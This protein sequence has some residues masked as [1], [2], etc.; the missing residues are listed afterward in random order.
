MTT[1]DHDGTDARRRERPD[2]PIDAPAIQA[3]TEAFSGPVL[4]P[5]D[6]AYDDA[7]RVWN[8][9]IDRYPA[10]IARCTGTADVLA[11][12]EFAREQDLEIAVRGGGHN[13]AGY[14]TCDG[15][16]VV[17]L[18]PMDWVDV[19]PEARTVRVGGGA[20]WG[21]VDRETQAFGL[22]APGG[23][24]STTGVAGLTLGGGYGYLRR[25]HGLSCDNLLAVDLV[26]ADGKFLTAS[27][28]EHAELFWAVRGGG[29]NFGIVTAFEFRLHPVG[30][31]VATVETW[32]S[33]SDAPSLVR[34]WR[35]AVATAPDEISAELV[36]WSVPDDPA[37]PDEL[38]TEPVAIVAAVYS[39]DVEAGERAMAPL[40]ELGA[41]LFDFSGPTPYVDLQQDFDPF[42][43]A[44]EFRYYAKSIFLD[45]LTDE[46][47]ETILE[48]AA[49]RPHYRVL[50]DIW[51]LGGAIADVSE[52]ETAYS[53]REHPYLLAIDATWEDPDDDE[54]VVAWSRA[55]WEDMREFSPGGL[56]LNFPGLEG[57]REDQLRETHGS[58]TY[59]RLVEIKTK[60]DPENAF[61]RNQNVEPDERAVGQ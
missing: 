44:G 32:H 33:L 14:A 5:D 41:P 25:K 31:E 49:S 48:R 39:G 52:T 17:D 21:V 7:R 40:R 23:V 36:F 22:A 59:D 28:S 30:P 11:A 54:R 24:V 34:E 35:D 56:Y 50:L 57:E 18:S 60:Y 61:R 47:I 13:V 10:V 51:Q 2:D 26:T 46:A 55:F 12:L 38:R 8:G 43:P 6:E 3:F 20:T 27:E 1:E 9:M 15:G 45:E 19:D 37:F 53:G 58:E 16:I 4:R 29:G 42:F